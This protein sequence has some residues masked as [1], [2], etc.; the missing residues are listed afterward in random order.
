M[1]ILIDSS[2]LAKRYVAELD[3]NTVIA[4]CGAADEIVLSMIAV[5]EVTAAFTRLRREKKLSPQRYMELKNRL[6]EDV[7]H[8]SVVDVNERILLAAM[9]CAEK[10]PVRAMDA[11]H[12]ATGIE[13]FVD[14]FVTADIKQ[15]EA[16]KLCG[17]TV[18]FVG[19]TAHGR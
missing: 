16:G 15:A 11:I 4:M 5:I 7:R 13:A 10:T 2:A 17:L 19:N 3:S 8:A 1:K 14:F 6:Y 12:L 18:K 9:K